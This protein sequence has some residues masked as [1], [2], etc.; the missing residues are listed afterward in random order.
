M[1][2]YLLPG[3]LSTPFAASLD[4]DLAGAAQV[5]TGEAVE[6]TGPHSPGAYNLKGPDAVAPELRYTRRCHRGPVGLQAENRIQELQEL[7]VD[8]KVVT[9]GKKGT[10]YF[11]RRQDKYNLASERPPPPPFPARGGHEQ[12]QIL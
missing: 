5:H 11:R 3:L 9:V 6:M 1:P 7:N 4:V 12:R 10:I 8:V 2:Q